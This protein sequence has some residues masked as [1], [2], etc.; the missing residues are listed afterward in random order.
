MKS[1]VFLLL[2]FTWSTTSL[3]AIGLPKPFTCTNTSSGEFLYSI[4]VNTVGQVSKA[5]VRNQAVISSIATRLGLANELYSTL[6]V[7][8]KEDNCQ[9]NDNNPIAMRCHPEL[10]VTLTAAATAKRVTIPMEFVSLWSTRH[11]HET[12]FT[13]WDEVEVMV[14]LIPVGGSY[15]YKS[16]M[17]DHPHCL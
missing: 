5:V 9:S 10:E 16:F 7:V 17:V 2:A 6:E 1:A 4:D 12:A 15:F 3:A 13:T 8:S 14:G 11:I